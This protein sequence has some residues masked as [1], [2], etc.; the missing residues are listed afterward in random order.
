LRVL[1]KQAALK[2]VAIVIVVYWD[3]GRLLSRISA[4]EVNF[5]TA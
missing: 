3:L 2:K 5:L 4:L 1:P